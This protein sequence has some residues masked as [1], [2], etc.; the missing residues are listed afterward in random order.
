MRRC[1]WIGLVLAG[2]GGGG[3]D[4]FD[5]GTIDAAHDAP[6]CTPLWAVDSQTGTAATVTAGHLVMTGSNIDSGSALVVSQ[7]GLTGDFDIAFDVTSF[8]AG[9][10]GAFLQA[11][12]NDSDPNTSDFLTAGIGTFPT[13]GIS[14]ADQP[15]GATD[16]QA[17]AQT[18]VTL[19]LQRTGTS[20]TVTATTS[21]QTA[22]ITA[23]YAGSPLSVG[24]QLG[25]NNGA[26]APETRAEIDAFTV[27]GTGVTGDTFDCDS[28]IP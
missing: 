17:T 13:V 27:T 3:G 7:A 25:S 14:A 22:T 28:L 26:V 16:I 12:V 9:G 1:V 10:T 15:G 21:D 11:G 8:S 2:C 18:A 24:L 5:G 6:A 20:V 19:R 4:F 23:T